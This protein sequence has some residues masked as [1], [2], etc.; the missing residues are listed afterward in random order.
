MSDFEGLRALVTG[1]ASGIGRAVAELMLAR[2]D[3]VAVADLGGRAPD[4]AAFFAADVT[5]DA[6]VRA[7]VDA[8]AERVA[9]AGGAVTAQVRFA[10]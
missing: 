8:A 5:D 4:G 6:A 2:G 9:A 3:S 1:G 7:A 10:D